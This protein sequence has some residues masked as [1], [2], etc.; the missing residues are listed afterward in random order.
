MK[1][2][3]AGIDFSI[4]SPSVLRHAVHAAK[5]SGAP[6][7]A[8]HV[9]DSGRIAHW[10]SGGGKISEEALKDQALERMRSLVA[11]HAA[12]AGVTSEVRSGRPAAELSRV[13][14]EQG[15]STLVIAANDLTKKR[16]GSV[17]SACVR[18]APC[19]VLVLRDWQEGN[20]RRIV[21]CTDFSPM[22]VRALE[23]GVELATA[24]GARLDTVHVLYP[25]DRDVWGEVM[26]H[27]ADSP[28][29]YAKECRERAQREA[30][31]FLAP[32][33]VALAGIDHHLVILES[34]FPSVALTGYLEDVGADLAVL[35]TR[36]H[37]RVGGMLLGTNAE[38]LLHDLP[39]SVLAVRPAGDE[40]K[41]STESGGGR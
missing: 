33:S 35:G 6:V 2:I 13:V 14:E 21:V 27:Q 20:F 17:A 7:H 32:Q 5:L 34:A 12:D 4:S 29:P 28:V 15:A 26:E 18:T 36:G 3:L 37:S 1:P 30:A 24:N 10:M 38:R 16:L 39:V 9:L 8:V 40:P 31:A 41:A 22:S 25:P 19:D 11:A 23:R